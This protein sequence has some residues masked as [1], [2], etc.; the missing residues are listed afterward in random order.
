MDHPAG[1]RSTRALS[2]RRP[3]EQPRVQTDRVRAADEDPLDGAF[4]DDDL[5]HLRWP[6]LRQGPPPAR[7]PRRRRTL[8]PSQAESRPPSRRPKLP[9]SNTASWNARR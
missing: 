9:A 2:R 1:E 5:E 7:D 4:E 6:L 3:E 8:T